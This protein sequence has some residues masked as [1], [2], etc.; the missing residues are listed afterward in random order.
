MYKIVVGGRFVSA[1]FSTPKHQAHENIQGK[2][3]ASIHQPALQPGSALGRVI[4]F[5]GCW[6]LKRFK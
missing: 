3:N 2:N 5:A 1:G 4:G 6:V